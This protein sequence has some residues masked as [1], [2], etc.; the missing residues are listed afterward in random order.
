[1]DHAVEKNVSKAAHPLI[2]KFADHSVKA[3]N[4]RK[5][6]FITGLGLLVLFALFWPTF[7]SMV[8]IWWRSETF[9][10]GFLIFPISIFLVWRQRATLTQLVPQ[11]DLRA[12]ALLILLGLA[13]MLA[14]VADVLVIQQLAFVGMIP[15]MVCL[16]LGWSVT[17]AIIFPLGFLLFAVPMG[18]ALIPPMM[19]FTADFT[20]NLLQLT[21]IPVYRQGTFFSIPSGDWSVVEG[22]SGVRY[23]IASLTLG[24]LYA[25]LNYYSYWRRALFI[26]FSAMMP[27]IANGF[28][29]YMIV[30]I[31]HLSD[32]KLALGVDHFIYGWVFFGI[33]MMVMFW[34][35]TFWREREPVPRAIDTG[36]QRGED[37]TGGMGFSPGVALMVGL[38]VIMIWP[39][40]GTYIN[41]AGQEMTAV[42]LEPPVTMASWQPIGYRITEW[43]PHY[44]NPTAEIQQDYQNNHSQVGVYLA[45]YQGQ[46]Q[47]A[48]L[49]NSQ[50]VMVVQK[51]PVWRQL[52]HQET[53]VNLQGKQ[54]TVS[55]AHLNSA[56]QDLLVWHWNWIAGHY[57]INSYIAKLL[58]A[59]TKLLGK[60]REGSAIVI[61]TPIK[62]NKEEARATMQHFLDDMLPAIEARL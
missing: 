39:A 62:T 4:W 58:E 42:T 49:I 5:Y 27:I 9:A 36:A 43:S 18:E 56:H 1:M 23:L 45:Y 3:P 15:A 2:G 14:Q 16:L 25:Y 33:V 54:T 29:A 12:L 11:P 28:R 13:W 21:G 55:E 37:R 52:A 40:W 26:A 50:N 48:E 24:C 47:G 22:C 10:H 30:M 17:K 60:S 7:M 32:M 61:Y 35:G 44:V 46:K 38:L 31:A 6:T 41:R 20:I 8:A 53:T 34:I 57:T 19:D 51:H 59:G